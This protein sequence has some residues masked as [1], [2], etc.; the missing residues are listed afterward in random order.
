MDLSWGSAKPEDEAG[1]RPLELSRHSKQDSSADAP[2]PRAP[3]SDRRSSSGRRK[4]G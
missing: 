3:C 2:T 1:E 4:R